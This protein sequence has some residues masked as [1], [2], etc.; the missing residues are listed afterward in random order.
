MDHPIDATDPGPVD[1]IVHR[2]NI[3][4]EAPEQETKRLVEPTNRSEGTKTK[5]E[6]PYIVNKGASLAW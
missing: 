1:L 2:H 4:I 6:E 3:K 5:I